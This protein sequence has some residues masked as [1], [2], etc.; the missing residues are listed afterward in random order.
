MVRRGMALALPHGLESGFGPAM[1]SEG[2][3]YAWAFAGTLRAVVSL[4]MTPVPWEGAVVGVTV[5]LAG[6]AAPGTTTVIE[7]EATRDHTERML[8][9][10][11]VEVDAEPGRAALNGAQSRGFGLCGENGRRT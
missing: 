2:A 7:K 9:A 5:L 11:G 10:F 6:L 1:F 4:P 3:R 8:R